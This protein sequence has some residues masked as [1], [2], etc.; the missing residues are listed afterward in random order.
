MT[1]LFHA[2]SL[3]QLW[4]MYCET[5]AEQN[6]PGSE[7]YNWCT[8]TLCDFWSKITPHIIQLIDSSKQ[9]MN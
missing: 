9:V 4:T 5:I 6:Q 2:F 1:S 8:L 7:C 3:C